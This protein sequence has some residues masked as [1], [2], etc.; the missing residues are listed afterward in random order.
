MMNLTVLRCLLIFSVLFASG[1]FDS[2]K[3]QLKQVDISLKK[4]NYG[5]ALETLNALV[6]KSLPEAQFK[7][8]KLYFEGH[9]VPLNNAKAIEWIEK[10]GK[11]KLEEAQVFLG[12]HYSKGDIIPRDP[13]V[14]YAWF[15]LAASG[16]DKEGGS[17]A[18]REKLAKELSDE[19]IAKAQDVSLE[20]LS[21]E[22][23]SKKK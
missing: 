12:N 15:N 19:Q 3:D 1:C 10:A 7:L 21:G 8:G 6:E 14:A 17:K 5:E 23:G 2:D 13:V 18:Q 20:F 22:K 9:G 4:K 11:N 16:K